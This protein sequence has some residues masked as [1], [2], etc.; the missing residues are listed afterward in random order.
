MHPLTLTTSEAGYV[1]ER[2]ALAINKAVDTGLIRA[3]TRRGPAGHGTLRI[4][5]RPELRFLKL[6][7]VLNKDLTPIG[8]RKLY[9]AIRRLP[10]QDH[11]LRLG[12]LT[13][14]LLPLD[15]A[16]EARLDR[17]SALK[18]HVE[19]PPSG[20]PVIRGTDVPVYVIASLAKG[21]TI[22]EILEDYP[23]L[24]RT[25]VET[26]VEY[27]QAYPKKGR[28]YPARSFKRTIADLGLDE[29]ETERT[30]EGPRL[31]PV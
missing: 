30:R 14:E 18:N 9:A 5:G 29:I 21:E 19:T 22:A 12:P 10:D 13:V 2:P 16:I 25:Q 24:T 26:A 4:L 7:D 17:L 31:I 8:Q 23:S 6:A 20:E 15:R 28:P 11:Q 1:L 27:A 3:N